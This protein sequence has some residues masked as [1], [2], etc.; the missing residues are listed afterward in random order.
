MQQR[1]SAA[2][3]HSL[4]P[5]CTTTYFPQ[6]TLCEVQK[7]TCSLVI[8]FELGLWSLNGFFCAGCYG[9][10]CITLS[11]GLFSEDSVNCESKSLMGLLLESKSQDRFA[12]LHTVL[13][14]GALL[15]WACLLIWLNYK[16]SPSALCAQK[17][18]LESRSFGFGLDWKHVWDVFKKKK[19]HRKIL[20]NETNRAVIGLKC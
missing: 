11:V 15:L 5:P 4:V 14:H 10:C 20:K 13:A 17:H 12:S 18:F 8:H 3:R 1:V 19:R 16:P 9:N 6:E 7:F 2:G